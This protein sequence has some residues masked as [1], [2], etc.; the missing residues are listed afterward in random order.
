M[1]N[2]KIKGLSLTK[3][4]RRLRAAGG[5]LCIEAAERIDRLSEKL[6]GGERV[7]YPGRNTAVRRR[8]EQAE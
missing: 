4:C 2:S 5:P 8:M 1:T 7:L 6:S 3:L